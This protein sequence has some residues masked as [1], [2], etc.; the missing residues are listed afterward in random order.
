MFTALGF[1]QVIT[2][3]I[4][5]D[6]LELDAATTGLV[7]G[8]ALLAAGVGLI[9]AQ[10][11]IVPGSGW[12]PPSLLRVGGIVAFAGF[13][14]LIVDAGPVRL[15]TGML[16]I[17]LGLGIAMPGYTAGATL[18]VSR[19]EQGGLAGLTGATNGLTFV[20]SPTA[21][22]VLYGLWAPLPIIVGAAIMAAVAVFVIAHPRF[23]RFPG[24]PAGI[25]TAG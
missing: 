17:G 15:F 25:D 12:L 5:Q 16:L 20:V 10:A 19:E 9:L 6:R 7:T 1:I 21:G 14:L 3:F 18:L 24:K 22:T 8:G 4:V 13:A 23:R 11:L 2:G